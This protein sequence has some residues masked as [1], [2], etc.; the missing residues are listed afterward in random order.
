MY[1][2]STSTQID[3]ADESTGDV[4]K[5]AV[6]RKEGADFARQHGMLFIE[7]S[8][9]T[10]IGVKQA[11]DELCSKILDKPSIAHGGSSGSSSNQHSPASRG[12]RLTDDDED[13]N[14]GSCMSCVRGSAG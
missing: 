3:L 13:T 2:F 5:R 10:Q 1:I 14:Q 6:S 4:S 9:K 11:F 7:A 12:L 8:A